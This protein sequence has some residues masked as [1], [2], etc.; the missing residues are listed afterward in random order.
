MNILGIETSCDETAAAVIQDG[1]TVLTN[2]ILSQIDIHRAYGG[3]V[4]EIAARSHIEAILPAVHQA[5]DPIGWDHIDAIAVTHT[6]GLVGSLL[7]GT[8]AARTLALVHYKPLYGVHHIKSHIYANWL[9]GQTPEFPAIALVVSGGHTQLIYLRNHTDFEIIGTTRDDAVG[10]AFDKVA[11]ILGLPYPGG[12]SI[13]RTALDGDPTAYKLPHP[14]VP[15]YDFSF[16]GLKTATLRAIQTAVD[17]PISFPSHELAAL[18]TSQ[19]Q[20]D[21]AATFEQTAVEIL[22]EKLA[23]SVENYHP[24]S[25]LIAGGVSANTA[26]RAKILAKFGEKPSPTPSSSQPNSGKSP[27]I[28]L[29]KP[30]FSTDNAAMVASAAFFEIE[31]GKTPSDPYT[32]TV[33]PTSQIS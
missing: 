15:G 23:K 16:S 12:P 28:F 18:L 31:T 9:D 8:L 5:V 22:V 27:Q 10:E 17:R 29:P 4:P 26:L 11:K 24:K 6:P 2:V 19:Q 13:S 3:V 30:I 14:Q 25:I 32:L 7:I 21:F 1:T 33:N 20:R